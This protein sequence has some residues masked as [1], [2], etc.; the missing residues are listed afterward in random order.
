MGGFPR[1]YPLNTGPGRILNLGGYFADHIVNFFI[2]W[3]RQQSPP[4]CFDRWFAFD[5]C[6]LPFPNRSHFGSSDSDRRR[7]LEQWKL[8]VFSLVFPVKNRG[9]CPRLFSMR[10]RTDWYPL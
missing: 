1:T 2:V 6:R 7:R 3:L 10:I 4:G 8:R 9:P 5:A